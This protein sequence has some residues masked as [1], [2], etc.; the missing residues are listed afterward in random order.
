[1][2]GVAKVQIQNNLFVN[3][4]LVLVGESPFMDVPFL[5]ENLIRIPEVVDV[6]QKAQ[7]YW[8]SL[9]GVKS[10]VL[11]N[12]FY[13]SEEFFLTHPEFK[14]FLSELVQFGLYQRCLK[15]QAEKSLFVFC[16]TAQTRGH[17]LILGLQSLKEFV[18]KHPAVKTFN[19]E[20]KRLRFLRAVHQEPKYSIFKWTPCG[21]KN[22]KTSAEISDIIQE[23]KNQKVKNILNL[24]QGISSTFQKDLLTNSISVFDFPDQDEKLKFIFQNEKALLN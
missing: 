3:Y 5:R 7:T 11:T 15:T 1:M 6:L 20:P 19:I 4:D 8:D 14:S 9:L 10:I 21:I 24:G 17:L 23:L 16:N 13:R 2:G 22:F 12:S 18:Y